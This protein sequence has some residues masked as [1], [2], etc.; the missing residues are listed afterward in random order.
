MLC[1][2]G[3]GLG[4]LFRVGTPQRSS[5]HSLQVYP[6]RLGRNGY[7][8]S[9]GFNPAVAVPHTSALCCLNYLVVLA[10]APSACCS[11]TQRPKPAVSVTVALPAHTCPHTQVVETA[12]TSV[13]GAQRTIAPEKGRHWKL[14]N[15]QVRN[16]LEGCLSPHSCEG[17]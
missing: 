9:A 6:W 7:S 5:R 12:L 11:L 13:H 3:M 10:L 1:P 16:T 14:K 2:E 8:Q 4:N 17:A 15:P